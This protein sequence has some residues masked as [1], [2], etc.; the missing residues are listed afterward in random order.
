ME[1][2]AKTLNISYIASGHVCPR[3]TQCI[4][5]ENTTIYDLKVNLM[6][7]FDLPIEDQVLKKC[8]SGEI[9]VNDTDVMQCAGL[10]LFSG[11]ELAAGFVPPRAP[12]EVV[13]PLSQSSSKARRKR[14]SNDSDY[15]SASDKAAYTTPQRVKR[16]LA[17][18][19]ASPK[20][21]IIEDMNSFAS[22]ASSVW[23]PLRIFLCR[24]AQVRAVLC[25]PG[26]PPHCSLATIEF[27]GELYQGSLSALSE[28]TACHSNGWI[29][30]FYVDKTRSQ[31]RLICN[32]PYFRAMRRSTLLS[33]SKQAGICCI[34]MEI[35]EFDCFARTS[36]A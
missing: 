1:K 34:W 20:D 6:V 10:E 23:Q 18:A 4:I 30:W 3:L 5:G 21:D 33:A 36:S 32:H 13:A 2:P 17:V 31:V 15:S 9:L 26:K 7:E 8:P 29:S 12:E 19:K 25:K 22:A 28:L 14:K 35:A 24:D 27:N 16:A 11:P